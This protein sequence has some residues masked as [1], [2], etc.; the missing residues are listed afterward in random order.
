MPWGWALPYGAQWPPLLPFIAAFVLLGATLDDLVVFAEGGQSAIE[1]LM[2]RMGVSRETI[3]S[4]RAAV[5]KCIDFFKDLWAVLTGNDNDA[6]AAL[7]RIRTKIEALKESFKALFMGIGNWIGDLFTKLSKA[8]MDWIPEPLKEFLGLGGEAAAPAANAPQS[9]RGNQLDMAAAGGVGSPAAMPQ[10]YNAATL[11]P[12]SPAALGPAGGGAVY[13]SKAV[14]NTFSFNGG[15]HVESNN[16]DPRAVA[17]EI[18]M[19][20]KDTVAQA[21]TSYGT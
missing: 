1:K 9:S 5:K 3:E 12:A 15:I 10:P 14:Q 7:E 21:E 2:E 11:P 19:A 18:P 8:L 20:F 4:V 13:N 17:N 16:A 6:A